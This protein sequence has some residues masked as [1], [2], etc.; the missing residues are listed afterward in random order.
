MKLFSEEKGSETANKILHASESGELVIALLAWTVNETIAALDRK[1]R[2]K[3]ISLEERDSIIS[4]VVKVVAELA[5]KGSAVIVP[6]R[7]EYVAA[8]LRLVTERH[9]SADDALQLFSAIVSFSDIF[10]A[11]DDLL[12][13]AARQEALK[14]STSK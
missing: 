13:Q 7:Q 9:I 5:R 11:A 4:T 2:R 6:V 1:F 12:V 14:L 3:E 8:S 10:M